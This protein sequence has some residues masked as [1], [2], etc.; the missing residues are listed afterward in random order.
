MHHTLDGDSKN[1]MYRFNKISKVEFFTFYWS[2]LTSNIARL[3]II[4]VWMQVSHMC[5]CATHN[6]IHIEMLWKEKRKRPGSEQDNSNAVHCNGTKDK[7]CKYFKY[8]WVFATYE[9]MGNVIVATHTLT[10]PAIALWELRGL[11]LHICKSQID[12]LLINRW[13]GTQWKN[14]W[15]SFWRFFGCSRISDQQELNFTSICHVRDKR[16]NDWKRS[17]GCGSTLKWSS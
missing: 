4:I 3:P 8:Y 7:M 1:Y 15:N 9:N 12:H 6:Q 5:V 13:N 10:H 16:R 11:F 17:F 2:L 14:A